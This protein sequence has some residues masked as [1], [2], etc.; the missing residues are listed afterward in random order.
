MY[1]HFDVK[2][3]FMCEN[4]PEIKCVRFENFKLNVKQESIRSFTYRFRRLC[5]NKNKIDATSSSR[6]CCTAEIA[7][8]RLQQLP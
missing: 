7:I 1:S 3:K 5:D 4:F 6:V 2:I 8:L